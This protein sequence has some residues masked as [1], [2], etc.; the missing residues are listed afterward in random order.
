MAQA[1]FTVIRVRES[2]WSTWEPRDGVYDLDWLEPVLDAAH[3]RGIKAIMGTPTYAVPPWLRRH[4]ETAAQRELR[5]ARPY[6]ARQDINHP[7]PVPPPRRAADPS[8]GA[9][10]RRTPA[11][12]GWQV[13]NEPGIN[14]LHNPDVFDGFREHPRALR[15]RR[16]PTAAGADLLVASP[17]R[18]GRPVA[19]GRQLDTALRPRLAALPERS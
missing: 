19:A 9:A 4:P 14:I 2:V 11:V 5:R 18:L 15:R 17:A 13:D 12:V 7:H 3:E 16:K 10:L 8:D 6:G 1:D